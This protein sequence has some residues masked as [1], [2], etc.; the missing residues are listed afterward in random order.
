MSREHLEPAFVLRL[1]VHTERT[2]VL[3]QVLLVPRR[4]VVLREFRLDD[5]S[6]GVT[7]SGV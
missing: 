5:D 2:G 6:I 3:N 4:P 1:T 7:T